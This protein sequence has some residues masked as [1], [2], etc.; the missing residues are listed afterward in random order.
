MENSSCKN[1]LKNQKKKK[2]RDWGKKLVHE[3]HV[4]TKKAQHVIH[5]LQQKKKLV[6]IFFLVSVYTRIFTIKYE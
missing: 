2:T 4:N 3:N 5:K 1:K 6:R